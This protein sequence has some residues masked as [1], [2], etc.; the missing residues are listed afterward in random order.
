MASRVTGER[1]ATDG[2]T[3]WSANRDGATSGYR[4]RWRA[5]DCRAGRV[6]AAAAP[7]PNARL[8]PAA[9][10]GATRGTLTGPARNAVTNSEV[11]P[12]P[13]SRRA[14]LKGAGGA[15]AVGGLTAATPEAP[16]RLRTQDTDGVP[17]LRGEVEV[18]LS[19]NG[20][21]E[22]LKVEP[23]TTL[24]DALRTRLAAPLTGSKLVCDAG[25][26]GACT[27]LIDGKPAYACTNLAIDVVGRQVTTVE[28]LGS[29]DAPSDV[30]RAFCTDDATMCGF[31]T[32]GFVVACHAALD[33]RPDGSL[34]ELKEELSGNLCR[35]GT[36]P[37]VF[38][39]IQ[40]AQ[41]ER[42]GA[43]KNGRKEGGR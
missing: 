36:Y 37:H 27:V 38:D 9:L 2:G 31:C 33:R 6:R 25:S 5:L 28:G 15:A 20:S 7:G 29:P 18:T 12:E 24:L 13:L 32:P 40:R 14:F 4:V 35:C 11:N 43:G 23:R 26:C 41:S 10:L 17:T 8:L 16:L 21:S 22:T 42:R 30:Q 3:T 1:A 39:A 19:I 34:E